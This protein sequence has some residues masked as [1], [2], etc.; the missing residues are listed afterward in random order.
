MIS[1]RVEVAAMSDLAGFVLAALADDWEDA[2]EG[3]T[4]GRGIRPHDAP[5]GQ[6]TDFDLWHETCSCRVR[7]RLLD[8]DSKQR[9][10][11][12]HQPDGVYAWGPGPCRECSC[13]AALGG[14]DCCATKDYPCATLRI[15]A[16]SYAERPGYLEKW[17]P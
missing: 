15:V 6:D 5:A 7:K 8:L 9:I 10:V 3:H 4:L 13:S 17:K 12:M 16:L 11:G 2:Q 1:N 14:S